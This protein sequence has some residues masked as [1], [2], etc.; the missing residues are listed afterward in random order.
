MSHICQ[1]RHEVKETILVTSEP[2][3]TS[4]WSAPTNLHL[5]E[6]YHSDSGE[7]HVLLSSVL[8]R[9]G[10]QI[11]KGLVVTFATKVT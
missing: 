7:D 10:S 8:D 4:H 6:S 1:R 9:K 11:I 5:T 2:S 3:L